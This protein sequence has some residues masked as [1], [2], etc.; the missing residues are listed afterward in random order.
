[1]NATPSV[2]DYRWLT[3]ADAAPW[4]ARA[5]AADGGL[6][7]VRL[8]AELRRQLSAPRTHLVLEQVDLRRRARQKFDAA[9]RMFFT[10]RSLE[11][12]TDE[13]VAAYKARR[14]PSAATVADFCCGIGGDLLA[15]AA[16]GPAV[17][18]DCDPIVAELAAANCRAVIVG[19]SAQAS[20]TTEVIVADVDATD[21]RSFAAWHIDLDRRPQG[22]RTTRVEL[23][24]PGPEAIDRLRTACANGAVK[25]APA[26]TLP[27]AWHD[28]AELEWISRDGEC[29]QLVC[30]FGGLAHDC[31]R[32]RATV[33]GK[34][35]DTV[36]TIVG[37][38]AEEPSL[39]PS[40]GAYIYEPDAA[41]LAAGL[42][43]VLA[44]EHGLA[45][46]TPG[47]AYLTGERPVAD[48][49]LDC[50]AVR[51]IMPLDVRQLRGLLHAR[52]IGR[53]EIK[54]RGVD[55]TPEK[56]R[57]DLKLAG[58]ASATL[59][60]LPISGRPTAVLAERV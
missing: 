35:A 37:R 26:A 27:A 33:I 59:I 16:R 9:E 53:L 3:S 47:I 29:R 45:G 38:A 5:A 56:L 17:G 32:R 36:R 23:H 42:S 31:G 51:E 1:V 6:S 25:L 55:G 28:E 19:K 30:W 12:S 15:L 46:I 40:L 60:L 50:F 48:A 7:T 54:K 22:R 52:H 18:V 43:P 58:T 13:V 49:A 24:E 57:R 20:A 8:T 2:D 10:R 11:Q 41:I 44:A 34:S 4:L 39:A 14:F 21:A